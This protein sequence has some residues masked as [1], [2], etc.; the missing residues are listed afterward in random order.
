MTG[1]VAQLTDLN[2]RVAIVTGAT[3]GLGHRFARVLAEAGATV[4]AAGR[5]GERLTELAAGHSGIHPQICDVTSDADRRALIARA[6]DLGGLDVLVNNAGWAEAEAAV[7]QSMSDVEKT[8]SVDVY[9]VWGLSVLA[10]E[11]MG[12][13]GGGSIINI[14]SMLGEV[15]SAPVPQSSYGAAK[16][17]VISMTRHFAA[18]WARQNIRVNAI[19][20]GWFPS[21]LTERML[22]DEQ[23]SAWIRRNTPMGRPGRDGELDGALMLFAGPGSTFITGQNLTVDGGW[24]AR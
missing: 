10:A 5:R 21:E 1:S 14:A 12:P 18:E 8:F 7:A 2:G 20:P 23:A 9:A 22:A 4:V 24:T 6:V 11:V 15:A 13:A 3:S 16:G 17:A 19:S